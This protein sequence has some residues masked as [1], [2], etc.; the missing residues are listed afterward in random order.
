VEANLETLKKKYLSYV[1]GQYG[2]WLTVFAEMV[3]R[4]MLEDNWTTAENALREVEEVIDI[5]A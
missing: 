3:P 4:Y 2:V 1:C 5:K